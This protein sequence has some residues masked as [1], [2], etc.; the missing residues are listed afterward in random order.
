LRSLHPG[1]QVIA[2]DK[3]SLQSVSKK[4]TE[5]NIN[6]QLQKAGLPIVSVLKVEPNTAVDIADQNNPSISNDIT[7]VARD[8]TM[9]II[10]IVAGTVS[11]TR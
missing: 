10:G 6:T 11:W 5:A 8:K 2:Q 1:V 9:L 4:L 3:S 7:T